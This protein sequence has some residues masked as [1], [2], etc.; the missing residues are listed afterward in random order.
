MSDKK[1]HKSDLKYRY[2]LDKWIDGQ[3]LRWLRQDKERTKVWCAVC[4]KNKQLS[5]EWK[6]DLRD[7]SKGKMY[8][9]AVKKHQSFLRPRFLTSSCSSSSYPVTLFYSD[10]NFVSNTQKQTLKMIVIS[11]NV[12]KVEFI[13]V[14][15]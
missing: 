2:L 8:S 9:K 15:N 10:T 6:S 1:I 5:S 11:N 3:E 7:H 13:R 14:L 4:N 12:T